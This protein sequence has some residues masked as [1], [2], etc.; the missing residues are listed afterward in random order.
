[1][2]PQWIGRV[3]RQA[4]AAAAQCCLTVMC[5]FYKVAHYKER[6]GEGKAGGA[7]GQNLASLAISRAMLF[8]TRLNAKLPNDRDL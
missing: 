8:I 4:A 3:T 1:M 5:Q 2:P 6:Q 7:V